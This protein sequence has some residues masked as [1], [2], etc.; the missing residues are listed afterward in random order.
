MSKI[1]N[2]L[3]SVALAAITL[4]TAGCK[5]ENV[6]FVRST[7]SSGTYESKLFEVKAELGSDWTFLS[8]DELAKANNIDKMDDENIKKALDKNEL[9]MD[10]MMAKETG[11]NITIMI[12]NV[13]DGNTAILSEKLY[14]EA[15]LEGVKS[16]DANAK[17]S[18]VKFGG[19]DHSA[20]RIK[21]E[22]NGI[23]FSQCLVFVKRG[24]YI[25]MFTFTCLSESELDETM[26][27]FVALS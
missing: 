16:T 22:K 6:E 13:K 9:F 3:L 4:V 14:A 7:S 1:R 15:N 8:D 18:T 5:A 24:Q 21:N 12:P 10:M 26:G 19:K 20:I 11:T 2:G 23:E 25:G 27:K 17:V